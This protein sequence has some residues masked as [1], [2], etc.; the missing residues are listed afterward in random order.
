MEV[1]GAGRNKFFVL[2]SE[3]I[4]T[5]ALLIAVNWG[6]TSSAVPICAALTISIMIQMHGSISG[7]HFNPAVTVGVMIRNKH[8]RTAF[9]VVYGEVIMLFQIFGA[10]LGCILCAGAMVWLPQDEKKLP[11]PGSHY[12]TQLCPRNGCNDGGKLVFKV[13]LV[14]FVMTFFFVNF[15]LQIKYQ[16]GADND[17][18]INGLAIGLALYAAIQIASGI[19]GGCINPAV[20]LVQTIFQRLFNGHAYPNT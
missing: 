6:G 3:M 10:V 2:W 5:A 8:D 16:N 13:F 12:I 19:S 4:G 14:E 9:G 1:P 18:P 15:V 20:G 11:E 17:T 7:G